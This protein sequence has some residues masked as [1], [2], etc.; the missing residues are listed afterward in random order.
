MNIIV[1]VKQVP[2][3]TEMSV[4]KE[5]GTLI[6]TGVPTICNP[7]DLAA[8][9]E[10]LKLKDRYN[11]HIRVLSMGPRQAGSLLRELRGMGVDEITLISDRAFAG[12]DTWATSNTLAKAIK[13]FPYDLIIAGRQAIDGDTAQVGPQTAEKLDIPQ[14]TLVTEIQGIQQGMLTV[15]K[16][17]EEHSEVLEVD[18][19]ALITCVAGNNKPRYARADLL[20][21]SFLAP[22]DTLTNDQLNLDR[23]H[24]GLSGSPTLVKKTFPRQLT[25]NHEV[26]TVSPAEAAEAVA[27]LLAP[28]LKKG[29]N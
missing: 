6:R 10:A 21:D 25:S 5:T 3:T 11:A 24:T 15:T 16:A 23:D 20:W 2:D 9:E 18:L 26:K 7:D 13:Q 8:V 4:D 29:G 19:P 27:S 14:I 22:V 12:S 17:Y 28:Y 1:L